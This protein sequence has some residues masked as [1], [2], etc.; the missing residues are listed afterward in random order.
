VEIEEKGPGGWTPS[1]S[2]GFVL[3]RMPIGVSMNGTVGMLVGRYELPGFIGREV[4]LALDE[5]SETVLA[6]RVP[7]ELLARGETLTLQVRLR[8]KDG[9]ERTVFEKRLTIAYREDGDPRLEAVRE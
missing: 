9:G 1:L 2:G 6:A 7:A 3:V 4:P 5:N 8:S